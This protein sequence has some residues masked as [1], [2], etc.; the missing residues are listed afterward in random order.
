[1]PIIRSPSSKMMSLSVA[2]GL[3][4]N[5]ALTTFSSFSSYNSIP[6]SALTVFAYFDIYFSKWASLGDVDMN[7]YGEP[8]I[9]NSLYSRILILLIT[10]SA[11]I[12]DSSRV[13]STT[14]YCVVSPF[15]ITKLKLV[16]LLW[17]STA[18]RGFWNESTV[19][20]LASK[21]IWTDLSRGSESSVRRY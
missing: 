7:F 15:C 16:S 19:G 13:M 11:G 18:T 1:M 17:W 14:G 3:K 21:A 2:F 20:N 9:S 8:I 10:L 6:C 12:L 4:K 5:P